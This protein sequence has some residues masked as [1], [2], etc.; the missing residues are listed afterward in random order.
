MVPCGAW[1]IGHRAYVCLMC[2]VLRRAGFVCVAA[3]YRYWPQVSLDG[4]CD[5][6]DTALD[7][8]MGSIHHF[9][10]DPMRVTIVSLSSGA[11][12]AALLLLRRARE[13]LS[14]D[15]AKCRAASWKCS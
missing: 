15:A 1:V 6:L 5:D 12:I 11:H 7:W 3:D 8:T 10:G 9:G 2:R 4:M 13:E 14:L